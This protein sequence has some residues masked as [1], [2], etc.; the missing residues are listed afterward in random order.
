MTGD[1][2]ANDWYGW[3]TNQCGHIVLGL[4]VSAVMVLIAPWWSPV[5]AALAYWVLVE[6]WA[7]RWHLLAD[8]VMDTFF[9][10]VG[11]SV[12][13]AHSMNNLTLIGVALIAGG[14]LGLG[15]WRRW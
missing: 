12:L 4:A 7:Q 15:V 2:F 10:M 9:V 3:L 6:G 14:A 1:D 13:P 11:A 8:S 5:I